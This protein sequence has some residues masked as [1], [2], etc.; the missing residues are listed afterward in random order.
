[1]N[2][3]ELKD[4]LKDIPDDYE[5]VLSSDEEGNSYSPLQGINATEYKY[6]SED[7]EIGLKDLTPK[8]EKL[9]YTEEDL[10]DYDIDA[11]EAMFYQRSGVD[12]V[13]F[14]P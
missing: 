14:W 8:H 1:M 6:S 9:G 3:K 4:I 10:F 2:V 7:R 12:C 5:I 13:V 11:D